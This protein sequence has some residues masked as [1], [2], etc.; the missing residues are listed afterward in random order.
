[1]T[2]ILYVTND[3]ALQ[4]LAQQKAGKADYDV[5]VVGGGY[6]ALRSLQKMAIDVLVFDTEV[7]DLNPEELRARLDSDSAWQGIP[8]VF[9]APPQAKWLPGAIPLR[10]EQDALITKPF[11]R[12]DIQHE[13]ERLFGGVSGDSI[14][15]LTEGVEID[16]ALQELRGQHGTALLTPTEFYLLMYLAE[17]AGTIVSS[18]EL[19]E[20]VWAFYPG[21]GSS[22]LVRSHIRN[23][24]AK[25]RQVSGGKELIRTT[26]GRGYRLG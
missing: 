3:P 21:T 13:L 2:T 20:N 9:L 6:E 18:A 25:L 26:P 24:R 10:G 1:M 23:L 14:T 12:A 17:R 16:R 15:A 5:V 8:I 22:E 11:A 19:L 4:S 7:D